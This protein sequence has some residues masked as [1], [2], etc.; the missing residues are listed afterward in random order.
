MEELLNAAFGLP[1][2]LL[3]TVVAVVIGFWLLMLCGAVAHD[4]FDA[5]AALGHRLPWH[6]SRVPDLDMARDRGRG[7][8]AGEALRRL[9]QY[10]RHSVASGSPS[11][12]TAT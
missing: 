8:T 5:D 7:P 11:S 12:R 4:V 2:T 10:S 9:P 3:T 1:A 6:C